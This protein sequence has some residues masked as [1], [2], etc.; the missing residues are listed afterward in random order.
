MC[1]LVVRGDLEGAARAGGGLLEDERDV[2]TPQAVTPEPG[3]LRALEIPRQVEEVV[4]VALTV[5]DQA[6][7]AAVAGVHCHGMAFLRIDG[8]QV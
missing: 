8:D 5:V 1:A 2:L 7:Q 6:E 4:Q 3:V